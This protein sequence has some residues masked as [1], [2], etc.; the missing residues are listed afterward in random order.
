MKSFILAILVFG[1]SSAFAHEGHHQAPGM[2]KSLYGGVVKAGKIVNVEY[3]ASATQVKIYPRAH[4]GEE[5]VK[6]LKLTLNAKPKKGAA[7]KVE[8]KQ[9]GEA[10][11]GAIDLK[12]ANRLPLE[13]TLES[14]SK[15]DTV[16]FQ[17]EE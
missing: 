10:H 14:G 9:E 17:V 11:I 15:K 6:D 2:L 8:L 16:K 13:L 7:Y 5:L 3:V 4:E 12:G 1:F